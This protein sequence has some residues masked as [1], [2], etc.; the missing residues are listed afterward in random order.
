[1][2][3][4]TR[5]HLHSTRVE[6]VLKRGKNICLKEKGKN[7]ILICKYKGIYKRDSL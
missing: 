5:S 2:I 6:I 3:K 7:E 4:K 1:M